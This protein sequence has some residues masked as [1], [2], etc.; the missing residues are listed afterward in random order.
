[1]A[2]CMLVEVGVLHICAAMGAG[3]AH[4]QNYQYGRSYISILYLS[5]RCWEAASWGAPLLHLNQS[6]RLVPDRPPPPRLLHASLPRL[7]AD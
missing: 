2:Y 6:L 4:Y 5:C 1:M 3:A 7:D